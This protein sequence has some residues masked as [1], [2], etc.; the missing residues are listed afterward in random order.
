MIND[1]R[2]SRLEKVLSVIAPDKRLA[3]A[4]SG[5]LDSRFL[6][7][8][9]KYLGYTVKLLTVKGPHI[10][11]EETTEA[12]QWAHENSLEL[13]LLDLNPLKMEA[14]EFNHTD[15]CYFCKKHLFL[16]LKRRATGLP[17]CDGTNH[18]DLSHYRPGLRALK[19][20]K[21]HSPLAEASFSKEDN[22]EI[23]ALIGLDHWD[24][25][26]RPCMLTRLPYNQK[27]LVS[28]LTAIGQ[29]ETELNRFF[30]EL[31]KGEIRFRL[32]KIS[33]KSFEMHIQREDFE[34]LSEE[35]RAGA[36]H[37]LGSFPLFATTQ[38]KPMEK[39][40]GY[41]DQLLEQQTH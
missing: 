40:S 37:L 15:R 25:A 20:L 33:P 22:R 9:A 16:E 41:F 10:S 30:T 39:L 1:P 29:A 3:I 24:Q 6:S 4:F 35:E 8:A 26:A 5:G 36:A 13:E 19:E 38:W 11:E 28:D 31:N 12:V 27:V 32:R 21:I 7:F 2:L 14:V 17:L 18:S 34:C 23:G